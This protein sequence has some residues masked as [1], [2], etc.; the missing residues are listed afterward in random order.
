MWNK[1][2]A[3]GEKDEGEINAPDPP[4]HFARKIRG[5]LGRGDVHVDFAEGKFFIRAG[6][7][8]A[9]GLDQVCLVDR[10]VRIRRRENFVVTV[11]TAAIGRHRGTIL[12]REAMIAVEKSFY[13][14]LRQ[15][16]FGVEAFRSVAT[17]ANLLRNSQV[18]GVFQ[19][20]DFVLGMTIRAG[21]G[22][23]FAG[24]YRFAVDAGLNITRLLGMT[25]AAG[26]G[27]AR[28]IKGRCGRTGR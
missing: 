17:T 6:M 25:H 2:P 20:F 9:A 15:I 1:H 16:V 27:L 13:A 28:E 26:F 8:F 22:V 4:V 14:V 5:A 10:R 23:A 18:G 3:D 12:R 11:A 24:G 21:R 19:P 7:T